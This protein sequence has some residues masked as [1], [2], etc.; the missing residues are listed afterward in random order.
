MTQTHSC[1]HAMDRLVNGPDRFFTIQAGSTL[2]KDPEF[3]TVDA[4]HWS[5]NGHIKGNGMSGHNDDIEWKRVLDDYSPEAGY[6]LWG[7]NGI[8]VHDIRQG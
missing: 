4:I 7:D 2:Y 5:D 8:S 3:P 1:T 6:S